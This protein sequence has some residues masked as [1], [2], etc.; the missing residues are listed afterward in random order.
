MGEKRTFKLLRVKEFQVSMKNVPSE[1]TP[2]E[3][4]PESMSREQKRFFKYWIEEL[5]N[6]RRVE[7]EDAVTYAS[8]YLDTLAERFI[9]NKN[10]EYFLGQIEKISK[11]YEGTENIESF[12]S[13][14]KRDIYL[15]VGDYEKAWYFLRKGKSV[16]IQDVFDIRRRC[17]DTTLSGHDL[18]IIVGNSKTR[19]TPFGFKNLGGFGR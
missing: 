18:F 17:E 16:T 9:N 12:V 1:I 3:C 11:V 7:T 15:F 4:N 14:T 13:R 6:G 10:V 19:L 8:I 5:S 2:I